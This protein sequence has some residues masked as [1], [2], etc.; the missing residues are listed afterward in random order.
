MS[1]ASREVVRWG[2]L[3]VDLPSLPK[4]LHLD[5]PV[6]HSA[7]RALKIQR[8]MPWIYRLL[9]PEAT[10]YDTLHLDY[11][12]PPRASQRCTYPVDT[13]YGALKLQHSTP[14]EI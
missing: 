4:I 11:P 7:G 13:G 9:C 10:A 5:Y 2:G 1:G 6:P 3:S 14:L 8:T 12:T